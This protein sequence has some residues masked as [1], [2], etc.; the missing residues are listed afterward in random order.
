MAVDHRFLAN[1]AAASVEAVRRQTFASL[2]PDDALDSVSRVFFPHEVVVRS[3]DKHLDFNHCSASLGD[4]SLNQ[5]GYG[6]DVDVLITELQRTHFV[7]VVALS[8]QAVVEFNQQSWSFQSGDCVLMSPNVRYNFQMGH[9]HTHLAIGI[10]SSRLVG[11]GRPYEAVH[12][13]LERA[14][15]A[16]HGGAGNLMGFIEYLCAEL[17]RGSPI[18]GLEEVVSANENSFLAMMRAALFDREVPVKQAS[19]LPVF[20]RRAE[21]FIAQ[22]LKDDIQLSDIV[23]ASGVP[24]RTLYHGFER[25]M[26]HSPMRWL[27]LRRLESARADIIASA[28]EISVTA[29]AN[30]Y[31]IGHGGRFANMYREI[32]GEPPS[33]TLSRSRQAA[34]R[35]MVLADTRPA[36]RVQ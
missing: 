28:G 15:D 9:D 26:G 7:F 33:V 18:F 10:P 1:S 19:V 22:H 21:Q 14:V 35:E 17:H 16:P 4:I 8:G 11:S 30:Q 34:L 25:F 2:R 24:A 13:V 5:I 29:L 20:V 3:R 31:W 6:A 12:N 23:G 27:R 32:Y 36:Q